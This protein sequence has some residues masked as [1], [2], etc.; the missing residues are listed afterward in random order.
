MGGCGRWPLPIGRVMT[1]GLSVSTL[2][3]RRRPDSWTISP[4]APSSAPA[5]AISNP[6]CV[7]AGGGARGSTT[8]SHNPR[9]SATARPARASSSVTIPASPA[10]SSWPT[11]AA[12]VV[13]P[14]SG[15]ADASSR[16]PSDSATAVPAPSATACSADRSSGAPR[17][18]T[19]PEACLPRGTRA[20]A[21]MNAR[22]C[23]A[24]APDATPPSRAWRHDRTRRRR[25]DAA[26]QPDAVATRARRPS[27]AP[28]ARTRS[29]TAP[30]SPRSRAGPRT[31][32]RRRRDPGPRRSRASVTPPSPSA[33][34]RAPRWSAP[35]RARARNAV[36]VARWSPL[37][38]PPLAPNTRVR[39]ITPVT[40]SS[41]PTTSRSAPITPAPRVD[42]RACFCAGAACGSLIV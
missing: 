8:S 16:L 28:T 15:P 5:A 33:P 29:G 9:S 3:A 23:A 41:R 42:A 17:I 14:A 40:I 11:S 18:T 35:V 32:E 36:A 10:R 13:C 12:S 21:T 6:R 30:T 25:S 31:C 22:P 1:I 4:A 38:L 39:A 20:A 2:C 26:R 27:P 37:P 19:A 34:A 24:A 7:P